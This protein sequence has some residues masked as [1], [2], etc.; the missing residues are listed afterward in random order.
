MAGRKAAQKQLT[1]SHQQIA[2]LLDNA[3]RQTAEITQ[4]SELGSLLQVCT[5]REEVFR[6]LPER[7]RRLFPGA[8]G[9]FSLLSPSTNR[10][11]P[12]V[13]WGISPTDRLFA[14]EQ[15]PP[16]L[17]DVAGPACTSEARTSLPHS[18]SPQPPSPRPPGARARPL[19]TL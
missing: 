10:V 1:A 16:H 9:A 14:P 17:R 4:I 12:F 8:S 19:Q 5:S 15:C 13:E 7:L 11:Y 3:R 6:L 18:G 2:H